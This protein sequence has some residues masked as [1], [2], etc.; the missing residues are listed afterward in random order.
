V[1]LFGHRRAAD[2]IAAFDNADVQPRFGQIA[3]ANETVMARADDQGVVRN[4]IVLLQ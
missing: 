3:R 4:F 2:H 1:K